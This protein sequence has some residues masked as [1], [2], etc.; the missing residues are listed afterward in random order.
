MYND[1]LLVTSELTLFSHCRGCIEALVIPRSRLEDLL[2][3]GEIEGGQ[4][5]KRREERR[6]RE[7]KGRKRRRGEGEK[8]EGGRGIREAGEGE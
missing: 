3:A 6:G 4:E 1:L 7:R 2:A 8:E 5:G